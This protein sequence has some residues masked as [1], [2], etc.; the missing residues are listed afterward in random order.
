MGCISQQCH[1]ALAPIGKRRAI[2]ERPF[3]PVP[4]RGD[5]RARGRRPHGARKAGEN[6]LP[7]AA[8]APARLAPLVANEGNNVDKPSAANR[9]MDEMGPAAQPEIDR[10]HSQFRRDRVGRSNRAPGAV[11]REAWLAR[12]PEVS[13]QGRPQSV[14]GDQR[15]AA[16]FEVTR[17]G[18]RNNGDAVYVKRE[19]LDSAAEMK[20][21]AGLGACRL[22]QHGLQVTAMN[23]PVG[24][25]VTLLSGCAERRAHEHARRPRVENAKL[26]GSDDMPLKFVRKPE[27]DQDA[28]CIGRELNAGPDLFQLMRL[29]K[30]RDAEPVL[31][32]RQS[33]AQPSDPR[34]GDDDAVRGRHGACLRLR[35]KARRSPRPA[36][37]IPPGV[38]RGA[39]V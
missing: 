31:R 26:L 8:R 20:N 9:V 38:P 12:M 22:D 33:G 37:R 18:A 32:E 3:L 23:D 19:I 29:V 16:I 1:G 2:E 35:L 25:A 30:D 36:M 28:R 17:S 24:C 4:R 10:R 15:R 6:F 14:R 11:A 34:A 7:L 39:Q 5:N 13:A 27:P 21:D